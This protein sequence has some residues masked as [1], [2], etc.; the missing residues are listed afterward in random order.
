MGIPTVGGPRKINN[1]NDDLPTTDD[2]ILIGRSWR[3]I[4]SF[5]RTT[6]HPFNGIFHGT[7]KDWELGEESV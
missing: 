6:E 2:I 4:Y 5:Q 3:G 7:G 1:K